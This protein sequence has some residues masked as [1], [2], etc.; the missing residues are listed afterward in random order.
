[1]SNKS[2]VVTFIVPCYNLGHVLADCVNSILDQTYTNLEVLIMDDCSPD[3]TPAVAASFTDPRVHHVRHA[4]NMGHLRNYNAGIAMA[5]GEYIWLISADDRLRR[6]YIVERFV[7]TAERNPSA[8]YV[9]CPAMKFNEN[10]DIGIYGSI[11]D[12][13]CVVPGLRFVERLLD[14]NI[15]SAPTGMVRRRTYEKAGDFPLDLPFAGDWFLWGA[16]AFHGDVAYLAEPMVH[17]RVHPLNMTKSFFKR[18]AALV[19]DELKVQW[20]LKGLADRTDNEQLRRYA[21]FAIAR[22]YATRLR[23]RVLK[24]WPYGMTAEQFEASLAA[25]P[26]TAEEQADIRS[27]A[28]DSLGDACLEADRPGD[29]AAAYT[30]ALRARPLATSTRAKALLLRSG[31][32]GRAVRRVVS[33]SKRRARTLLANGSGQLA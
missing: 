18:A 19:E 15:V 21:R 14:G 12:R 11:G 30:L 32:V 13:D 17:Y 16:F 23:R 27:A 26:A 9:F 1:M 6:P 2:P 25:F 33:S 24:D 31:S 20:R 3:D 28:Y 29:A 8:A 7:E 4:Q 5:R 10:G 22:D